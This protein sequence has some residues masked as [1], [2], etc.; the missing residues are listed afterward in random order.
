M[1][2]LFFY[3]SLLNTTIHNVHY[4][5]MCQKTLILQWFPSVALPEKVSFFSIFTLLSCFLS[6]I[7]I[8]EKS[9]LPIHLCMVTIK[10]RQNGHILTP[11]LPDL[12]HFLPISLY[13]PTG[14]LIWSFCPKL[15]R[16]NSQHIVTGKIP[17]LA[18]PV[19]F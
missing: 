11:V 10:K 17:F 7:A 5:N 2:K 12:A 14:V 13:S 9:H 8:A 16:S 18:N 3:I 15:Y 6:N 4:R 19:I 1:S